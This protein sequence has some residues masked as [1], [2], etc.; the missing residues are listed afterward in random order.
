[1]L[2]QH[3]PLPADGSLRASLGLARTRR[4]AAILA[5]ERAA[6]RFSK[7]LSRAAWLA[8]ALL[9]GSAPVASVWL[10][11]AGPTA[12]AAA[13]VAPVAVVGAAVLLAR[14]PMA[15][16]IRLPAWTCSWTAWGAAAASGLVLRAAWAIVA[17]ATLSSDS[18]SYYEAAV[19]LLRE[20]RYAFDYPTATGTV[21]L[22]AWRP[23]GQSA[24]LAAWFA[25]F[26]AS[27][28]AIVTLNLVLHAAAAAAL[29]VLVR[30]VVGRGAVFPAL[31]A[32]AFWPLGIC[33]VGVPLSEAVST[34]TYLLAVLAFLPAR[35]GRARWAVLA[36][37]VAGL[38][39]LVRSSMLPVPLLWL[40]ASRGAPRGG[41]RRA[42]LAAA[43]A[44]VC[45]ALA[46]LP[47]TARNAAVLGHPVLI[48]TNGGLVLYRANNPIATGNYKAQG[49]RDLDALAGDEVRWS[50]TGNAWAEEWITTHPLR[51]AA[52][53]V[54]KE[55]LFWG[56]DEMGNGPRAFSPEFAARHPRAML[57][58]E[59]LCNA[60]WL[61]LLAAVLGALVVHRRR[62]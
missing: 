25:L 46:T 49:E 55:M 35:Q 22:L 39:A 20:G 56:S 21:T 27:P 24:L 5:A 31:V 44:T 3:A 36:G 13:A 42:L 14:R 8:L 9:A 34:L 18:L 60:W 61:A 2:V 57:G 4:G 32:F 29:G 26:G 38:G 19:R 1:M 15:G 16:V 50:A 53:A 28:A 33:S 47:W 48:S 41:V 40:A 51:F 12:Y 54:R 58:I 59:A 23:P 43:L 62:L 7:G 10:F 11:N 30:R 6:R 45:M 37:I 17:P 52:L